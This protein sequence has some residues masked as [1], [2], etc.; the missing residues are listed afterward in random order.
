MARLFLSDS[1]NPDNHKSDLV[2]HFKDASHNSWNGFRLDS[3]SPSNPEFI[4][5]RGETFRKQLNNN[6]DKLYFVGHL[7]VKEKNA[8]IINKIC[9]TVKHKQSV[10]T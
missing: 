7:S 3:T 4:C 1:L 6:H 5:A 10:K 8:L 2:L 9:Y